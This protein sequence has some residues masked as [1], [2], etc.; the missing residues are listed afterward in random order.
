MKRNFHLLFLVLFLSAGVLTQYGCGSSEPAVVVPVDTDGDGIT[1][2]QEILNGTDPMGADSD[3][4][5]F[6]DSDE[7]ASPY[8]P[9]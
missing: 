4:D 5:G 2:E 8:R 3:G 6:T 9:K 1:D 7:V